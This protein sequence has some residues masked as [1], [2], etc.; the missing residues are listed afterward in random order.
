[1]TLIRDFQPHEQE[2]N[3]PR[4]HPKEA[5]YLRD[6][7]AG[8]VLFLYLISRNYVR[9]RVKMQHILL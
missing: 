5:P 4:L 9:F 3:S 1:M 7:R 2:F 8:T 6:F